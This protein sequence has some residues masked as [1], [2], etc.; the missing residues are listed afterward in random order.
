MQSIGCTYQVKF[1]HLFNLLVIY[2]LPLSYSIVSEMPYIYIIHHST[3][4]L[5]PETEE[6][7]DNED[8]CVAR[9][10]HAQLQ[11]A[12]GA[13]RRGRSGGREWGGVGGQL[14]IQVCH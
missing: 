3:L 6:E 2:Q 14:D 1:R 13:S 4:A 8:I 9:P 5:L 7:G 11:P 10:R 12:A